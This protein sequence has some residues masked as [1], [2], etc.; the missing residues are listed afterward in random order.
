MAKT[1][2]ELNNMEDV[3]GAYTNDVMKTWKSHVEVGFL[4][5][6]LIL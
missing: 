4:I 2:K 6:L 1:E 3:G 5:I